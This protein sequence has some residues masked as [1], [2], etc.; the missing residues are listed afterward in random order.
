MMTD[1]EFA[2]GWRMLTSNPW[3][4]LPERMNEVRALYFSM[5]QTLTPE[6]WGD[7]VKGALRRCV[8]F[9]GT[10][11]LFGDASGTGANLDVQRAWESVLEGVHAGTYTAGLDERTTAA[12]RGIG[13][14]RRVCESR[15][16]DLGHLRR[17]FAA[18]WAAHREAE[19][20]NELT[21]AMRQ[22]RAALAPGVAT[23][24]RLLAPAP[25]ED[26]AEAL[27]LSDEAR[28]ARPA[29]LAG[30]RDLLAILDGHPDA[31]RERVRD[32]SVA[33]A[34]RGDE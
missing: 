11:E 16:T 21:P 5:A 26:E 30:F 24:L 23:R 29:A 22:T 18:A 32:R 12:L 25:P 28:A 31:E 3:P 17:E 1:V 20:R 4:R 6:E 15:E 19:R 14:I 27:R 2:V 9:P 7:T 8:H 13:G 10:A 34:E 33:N